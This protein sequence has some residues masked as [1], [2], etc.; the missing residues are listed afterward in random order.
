MS[1]IKKTDGL[2][3]VS[4]KEHGKLFSLKDGTLTNLEHVE[5]HPLPY[6]DNEGFFT[7]SGKGERYGS[8]SPR[9]EDVE[10]N[11]LRYFKAISEELSEAVKKTK[12]EKIYIFEPEHL[13]GKIEERL[14]NPTNIPVE[15]IAYGNYVDNDIAT[16]ASMLNNMGPNNID[17][18]NPASVAGEENAE[19]KRKILEVGNQPD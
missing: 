18:A 19:E 17:P 7:R 2:V 12:P 16:I 1:N 13:K 8:G 5:K 11:L 6:S 4:A 9:E 14:L 15:I 3:V 10:Q